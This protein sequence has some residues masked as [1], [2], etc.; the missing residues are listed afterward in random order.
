MERTTVDGCLLVNRSSDL[1]GTP[2]PLEELVIGMQPDSQNSTSF[3][4]S[5]IVSLQMSCKPRDKELAN[6]ENKQ[7]D[8]VEKGENHRLK[9]RCAGIIFF[10]WVNHELGCPGRFFCFCLPVY[11]V[12]FL[13]F[14][15]EKI[16][17]SFF[18]DLEKTWEE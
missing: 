18:C 12:L 5:K 15:A 10:F 9:S 6:K 14:A 8:P 13:L 4:S 2:F 17:S 16:K 11:F 3:A 1:G 7:F